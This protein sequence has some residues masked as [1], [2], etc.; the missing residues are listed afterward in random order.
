MTMSATAKWAPLD[1]VVAALL[2]M[3]RDADAKTPAPRTAMSL[4]ITSVGLERSD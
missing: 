2:K 1:D 3:Q 4:R